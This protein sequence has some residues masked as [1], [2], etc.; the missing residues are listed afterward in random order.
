LTCPE[1]SFQFVLI[2]ARAWRESACWSKI[3]FTARTAGKYLLEKRE[4]MLK[5]G[6]LFAG[7]AETRLFRKSRN[8][9][10]K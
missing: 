4:K 5:V 7:V 1:Q 10:E 6:A 3:A 8:S 2:V 9:L